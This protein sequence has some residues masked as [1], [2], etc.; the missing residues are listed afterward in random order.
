MH[1]HSAGSKSMKARGMLPEFLWL[2]VGIAIGWCAAMLAIVLAVDGWPF[3]RRGWQHMTVVDHK[4][5]A[6]W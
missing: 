6:G 5:K 3:R 2:A 1:W 4:R